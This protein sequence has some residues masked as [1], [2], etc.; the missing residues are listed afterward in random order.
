MC[1]DRTDGD[2]KSPLQSHVGKLIATDFTTIGADA[3]REL[4][5]GFALNSLYQA[6]PVNFWGLR[7]K[8]DL[9]M[10]RRSV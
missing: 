10:I 6:Y 2:G 5:T 3:V 8:L 1:G 9:L 4:T 7:S